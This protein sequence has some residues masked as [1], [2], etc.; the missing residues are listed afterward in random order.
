[1]LHMVM[2]IAAVTVP[3][4]CQWLQPGCACCKELH[5]S[6]TLRASVWL[7]SISEELA[8]LS[9]QEFQCHHSLQC[10]GSLFKFTK[11]FLVVLYI[12][13]DYSFDLIIDPLNAHIPNFHEQKFWNNLQE[14]VTGCSTTIF[15]HSH[16]FANSRLGQNLQNKIS[17]SFSQDDTL[18]DY[19]SIFS[20]ENFYQTA[21]FLLCNQRSMGSIWQ[22]SIFCNVIPLD[23]PAFFSQ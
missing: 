23:Y 10:L 22:E 21:R 6:Y 20:Q 1:M 17:C 3:V 5:P 12:V 7:G 13:H 8:R 14:S 18:P 2:S 15:S 4:S 19:L 16:L 9:L 11:D